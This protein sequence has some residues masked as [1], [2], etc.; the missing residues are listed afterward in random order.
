MPAEPYFIVA[1]SAQKLNFAWFSIYNHGEAG[2]DFKAVHKVPFK[3]GSRGPGKDR[4]GHKV[5][6]H[7][8]WSLTCCPFSVTFIIRCLLSKII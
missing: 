2:N 7:R 3:D 5:D 1:A 4:G 8:L 6:L